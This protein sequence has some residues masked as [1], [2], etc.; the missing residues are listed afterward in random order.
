M[1]QSTSA[2]NYNNT[3]NI[4]HLARTRIIESTEKVEMRDLGEDELNHQNVPSLIVADII[5]IIHR[6]C[7]AK[8]VGEDFMESDN[9]INF[10]KFEYLIL[11]ITILS[12]IKLYINNSSTWKWKVSSIQ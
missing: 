12:I 9:F 10:E 5:H 7:Q 8:W 4:N 1:R 11:L 3:L 2:Q 6:I